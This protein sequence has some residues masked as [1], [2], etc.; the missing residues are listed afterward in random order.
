MDSFRQLVSFNPQ[1]FTPRSI[2]KSRMKTNWTNTSEF[3]NIR[4]IYTKA[5]A[6]NALCQQQQRVA[7]SCRVATPQL[8]Q[9]P[10]LM[11]KN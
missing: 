9:T 1:F 2:R 8:N 3:D 4:I 10:N 11:L 6:N 5:A 7:L